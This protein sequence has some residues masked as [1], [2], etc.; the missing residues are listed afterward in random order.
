LRSL[1][2]LGN[3]I[4]SRNHGENG[5]QGKDVRREE[6]IRAAIRDK[7]RRRA[8]SGKAVATLILAAT[9]SHRHAK[10]GKSY[11]TPPLDK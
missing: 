10:A 4:S 3:G 7:K 1:R 9:S 6:R 5:V 2:N 8:I 11:P